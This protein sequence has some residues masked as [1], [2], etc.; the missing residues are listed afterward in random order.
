VPVHEVAGGHQGL[1]DS[2]AHDS[3][4]AAEVDRGGYMR[5][6]YLFGAVGK[7]KCLKFA[8]PRDWAK[9]SEWGLAARQGAGSQ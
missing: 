2:R 3:R 4:Q 8:R 7:V 5:K 9:C 6:F 1:L